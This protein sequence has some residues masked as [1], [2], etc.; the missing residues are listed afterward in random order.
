MIAFCAHGPRR[1]TVIGVN[2]ASSFCTA[3]F[4]RIHILHNYL[5][6]RATYTMSSGFKPRGQGG[7]RGGRSGF[8][9]KRSS[10]DDEEEAPRSSKKAKA[11]DAE[12]L[13]QKLQKDE[14]GNDYVS[15]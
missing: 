1:V 10:P 7:F 3:P 13:V 14:E 6:T 8:G 12:P 15:V 5:P 9:K 2:S 11:E 4:N